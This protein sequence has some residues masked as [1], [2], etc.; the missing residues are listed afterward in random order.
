MDEDALRLDRVDDD[1]AV[2]QPQAVEALGL[3][4]HAEGHALREGGGVRARL[5]EPRAVGHLV[6]VRVRV[7]TLGLE[8]FYP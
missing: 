4:A 2:A 5:A 7:R 1:H 8:P 3:L 6:R